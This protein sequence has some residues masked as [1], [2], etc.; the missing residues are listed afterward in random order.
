MNVVGQ[1][2]DINLS[3]N[4]FKKFF[5]GM[6]TDRNGKLNRKEFIQLI[7]SNETV[8]KMPD[9]DE[10]INPILQGLC[11]DALMALTDEDSDWELSL[12]EFKKCLD[13]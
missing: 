3:G 6:D 4:V 7:K 9:E 13:P 1:M 8:A 10:Y 2:L 12:H 11:S 5:E